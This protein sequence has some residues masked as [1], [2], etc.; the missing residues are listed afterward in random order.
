MPVIQC[1]DKFPFFTHISESATQLSFVMIQPEYD[2][3]KDLCSRFIT[4]LRQRNGIRLVPFDE[5]EWFRG[6]YSTIQRTLHHGFKF[7]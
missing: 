4:Q 5:R 3:P 2:V 7:R 6:A 1:E